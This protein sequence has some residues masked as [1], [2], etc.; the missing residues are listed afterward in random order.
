MRLWIV[1]KLLKLLHR[2]RIEDKLN[3]VFADMDSRYG[4]DKGSSRYV[5]NNLCT[6][7]NLD[8]LEEKLNGEEIG[9]LWGEL[10]EL[11]HV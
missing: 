6:S 11:T 2:R 7:A 5:F 9:E 1:I 4:L 10:S 8:F 3:I